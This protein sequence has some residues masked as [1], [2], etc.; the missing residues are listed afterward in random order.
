[1]KREEPLK[2]KTLDEILRSQN[3]M[4]SYHK[5]IEPPTVGPYLVPQ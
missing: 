3:G 4:P 1:M 2:G 5:L